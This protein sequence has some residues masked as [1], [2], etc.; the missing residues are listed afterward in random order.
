MAAI[1]TRLERTVYLAAAPVLGMAASLPPHHPLGVAVA[2]VEGVG[3]A[4]ALAVVAARARREGLWLVRLSPLLTA[5]VVDLAARNISGWHWDAAMAGG[6]GLLFCAV[7]PLSK[8]LRRNRP[9]VAAAP[10]AKA[11]TAPPPAPARD[12]EV[13]DPLDA[14]DRFSADVRALWRSAG[15]AGH[16]HVAAAHPHVGKPHDL[17][18]LL[19]SSERGR[20]IGGG[21]TRAAVAAAFAVNESDVVLLEATAMAGRQSGPGWREVQVIPDERKRRR[22]SPTEAERWEDQVASNAIPGSRFIGKRRDED[23]QVSY[24]IA[25]LPDSAGEPRIDPVALARAMGASHDDGRVFATVDGRRV[26]V[27]VW[28]DSPLSKVYP[29]TRALLTPDE[30]GWWTTGYLANGQPALNRVYTD[31]GAAHVLVVAPSGGGKTQLMALVMAAYSNFGAVLW[32]GT[33][34]P[35]EKTPL[36]GAHCARYGV[37]ALY[38]L[39]QLRALI[40]LMEIRGTMAWS[41]GKIHDWDPKLPGCPYRPLECFQDEFLSAAADPDYGDEISALAQE[42][43]VKG[44]KY[45]IGEV[46]AGQSAQ[47]QHGFPSLMLKN[48]RENGIP[49]LLKLAPGDITST[50]K[51]LGVALEYIP[52]ALPRSFSREAGGRIERILAGEAEPPSDSN[53]G[54]VGWTVPGRKPEVLRTLF[55][56]FGKGI[57]DLFS[58]EVYDLTA[59]ETRELEARS[60][61]FDWSLPPQPGEFGDD[62]D[63]E[64]EE[65][66]PKR[67]GKTAGRS[68]ITTVDQALA[69]IRR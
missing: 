29:A 38:M 46:I 62:P 1:V 33:E 49:V 35:D 52:D 17:T 40:A 20:P 8:T 2:T 6:W 25:E 67:G 23:R 63:D 54:G 65:P 26:L 68:T 50:F 42:V 31:R 19:R 30:N 41:D 69:A 44:R 14:T 47:V 60:L 24:W 5:G 3:V 15:G 66:A 28:D 13:L 59:H 10:E 51:D 7:A 12:V 4:A 36:L 32:L 61:L 43:S 9:A 22:T 56:D 55:A 53:T 39:R 58:A 18:M 16:T 57:D 37:G 34:A 21:L 45:G 48:I 11:L 27:A 64:D